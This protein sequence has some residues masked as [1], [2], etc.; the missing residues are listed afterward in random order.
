MLQTMKMN[1]RKFLTIAGFACLGATLT[2]QAA[3]V[4][5]W[6]FDNDSTSSGVAGWST[7]DLSGGA[8]SSLGLD[9]NGNNVTLTFDSGSTNSS[10]ITTP[11]VI[12]DTPLIADNA[13]FAV[14]NNGI[15]AVATFTLSGLTANTQYRLQF[16]GTTA[17]NNIAMD[18]DDSGDLTYFRDNGDASGVAVGYSYYRDFTLTG[19]DTDV[20]I[21]FAS[22]GGGGAKRI[23]GLALT[24][25]PESSTYALIAGMLGLTSVMLRRR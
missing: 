5:G 15:G 23:G 2:S 13:S 14:A 6:D 24:V 9:L 11:V 4:V 7:F 12:S 25:I 10:S 21:D 19:I 22:V 8:T 18:L 16:L 20:V 17:N 3:T 1:V